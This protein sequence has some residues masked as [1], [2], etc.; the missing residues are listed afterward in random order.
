MGPTFWKEDEEKEWTNYV[1]LTMIETY[2][3]RNMLMC[4]YTWTMYRSSND[5]LHVY[6]LGFS[7][8][9]KIELT[10]LFFIVILGYI[11]CTRDKISMYLLQVRKCERRREFVQESIGNSATN[12]KF[13]I[14]T[15]QPEHRKSHCLKPSQWYTAGILRT[16]LSIQR[17]VCKSS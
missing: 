15:A 3:E 6:L 1:I 17:Q 8:L 10:G 5:V 4:N 11:L 9:R 2:K 16:L 7:D 14:S 12:N 13:S